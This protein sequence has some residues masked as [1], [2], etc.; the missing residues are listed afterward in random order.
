MMSCE[1]MDRLRTESSRSSSSTWCQ[2]ARQHLEGCERCSQLQ[3]LLDN[4]EQ[5]EFPDALQNRIEAAI[6]PRLRQVSPLPTA[7]QVTIT[8]LLC[9]ISVV[10]AANS[11]LG[12]AGW[13][14]RNSLQVSVDFSLLGVFA[15]GLANLLAHRMTPGSGRGSLWLYLALPLSMLLAADAWLYGYRWNP[16]F[17]TPALSCWEIGVACAAV[18]APFFWL[19]LRRGFSLYPVSHGAT[20]G[21]L[22]G[23][24]GVAVLE[25]YCPYLDRLH[26]A[27]GHIGAAI[28]STLA[29]A[30]AGLI[31]SRMRRLKA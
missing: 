23:L 17:L 20:A 13:H 11:L 26:I 16:D 22:A 28:T 10:A 27:A 30:A 6:L 5:V 8:L 7:L 25:L 14:A 12:L 3:A 24:V 31:R 18:S 19:A 21:F 2:E 29:G 1:D 9:S 4:S 15:I